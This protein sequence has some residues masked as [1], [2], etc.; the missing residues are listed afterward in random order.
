MVFCDDIVACNYTLVN[1][2]MY[3]FIHILYTYILRLCYS[4]NIACDYQQKKLTEASFNFLNFLVPGCFFFYIEK[5]M[6]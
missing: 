1:C 4:F 5:H 3:I 2:V 6:C